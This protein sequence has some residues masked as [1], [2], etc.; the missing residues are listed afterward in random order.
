MA[1]GYT[2]IE[3]Q[4]R[5]KDATAG[6]YPVAAELD[7]GAFF[8]GG[9]MRLEPSSL[10]QLAL[11][12]EPFGMMLFSALFSGDVRTAYQQATGRAQ[13]EHDGRLR[14]RLWIDDGAAELHAIPWE[15]L[16]HFHDGRMVALATSAQTPFSRFAKLPIGRPEPLRRAPV[17]LLVALANPS[18]LPPGLAA[19]DVDREAS[20]IHEA[21][22]DLRRSKLFRVSI[23][24]GRSG[25]SPAVRQRLEGDGYLI[26]DGHTSWKNVL[27]RLPGRGVLHFIGHGH[28]KRGGDTG[29]GEAALFLEDA[30]GGWQAVEDSVLVDEMKAAGR[31][32]HLAFLVACESAATDAAPEHPFVGLGPKLLA[33]GVP[34]VVAMQKRVSMAAAR[35]LTGDFYRRLLEHGVIDR[36]LNEARLL[37][38]DRQQVEWAVPVLFSRLADNLLVRLPGDSNL[39]SADNIMAAAERL[40]VAARETDHG[41]EITEGLEEL[42][43]QW[44]QSH[45]GLVDLESGLRRTGED[46]DTFKGR[47]TAYYHR[48]MDAYNSETW[49]KEDALI[50]AATRLRDEVLPR[51]RPE[52]SPAEHDDVYRALTEHRYSRKRLIVGF[53]DFLETMAQGVAE[54]KTLVDR[55]DVKAAI[56]R[57]RDFEVEIAPSLRQARE[58]MRR[59]SRQVSALSGLIARIGA[60]NAR[61]EVVDRGAIR[62]GL[63]QDPARALAEIARG[64]AA[65]QG[66][67]MELLRRPG[68]ET[69]A[70]HVGRQIDE[71]VAVQRE[72]AAGGAAVTPATLHHLGML[73][74]YK[75]DH[76]TALAL[77][78]QA[79]AA[80]PE[81]PEAF[82]AIARLQH[83][84]ATDD[85]SR[86]RLE[87]AAIKLDEAAAAAGRAEPRDPQVLAL[88]GFIAKTRAQVA[89]ASGDPGERDAQ[90]ATAVEHFTRAVRQAPDNPSAHNGLGNV[91]AAVGD[92]ATAISAYERAVALEPGY[93]SAHH[94]LALAYEQM[95]GSEPD[96]ADD[97]CRKAVRSWR[98]ALD[99]MPADPHFSTDY[100]QRIEQYAARLSRQ[101]P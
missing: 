35:R 78:R 37:L 14:V 101:C 26:L 100:I 2:E 43:E 39:E 83:A 6:T 36:A 89:E 86:R 34:A 31:A 11:D 58:L 15:R 81:A 74:A 46:L 84:R 75:R 16:Y 40:F 8:K 82:E 65:A 47:F 91:A 71:V 68:G 63:G 72:M 61:G 79:A 4:V 53:E 94:D 22:G 60:A 48:F 67:D 20:V 80:A 95:M 7:D 98:R 76:E 73:A 64:V 21:L 88:R 90:L 92:V 33:A 44:H 93:A 54:I 24:P 97:W 96:L 56:G 51:M 23:M 9:A 55:G 85:V 12:P 62:A 25:L 5:A 41:R 52:M 69:A 18:G 17:D 50:R 13:A 49:I 87:P 10:L 38:F 66:V 99:L 30:D 59:L 27:R 42:L 32:P 77:F 57:K 28:F 70:A 45:Q 1:D 3:I 19:V 29:P